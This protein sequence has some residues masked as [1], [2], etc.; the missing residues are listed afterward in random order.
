MVIKGL[1]YLLV[2]SMLLSVFTMGISVAAQEG[3]VLELSVSVRD[4]NGNPI[5]SA[6]IYFDEI[7]QGNTDSD[8]LLT[9]SN[10]RPGSHMIEINL[11]ELHRGYALASVTDVSIT[12]GVLLESSTID[13]GEV[14]IIIDMSASGTIACRINMWEE[15]EADM[16]LL[17]SVVPTAIP[18]PGT[19]QSTADKI[20]W[21]GYWW[22]MSKGET[23][24]GYYPHNA[25]GPLEKYD[26]YIEAKYGG[27]SQAKEWELVNHYIPGCPSWFGHCHAWA[28]AAILEGEPRSSITKEGII[29]YV[30]DLKALLTECH[31][32]DPADFFLGTRFNPTNNPSHAYEDVYAN[33]FT[34][35]IRQWI[36]DR[37][38]PLVMD[39]D[40]GSEV[41]NHPFYKYE[42]TFTPADGN[43]VD[44]ACTV[45]H[46]TD[47]VHA[48]HLSDVSSASVFTYTYRYWITID[49]SGEIVTMPGTSGWTSSR[50]PDFL[51]HPAVSNHP[52]PYLKCDKV[53][54]IV[55]KKVSV[56]GI[57]RSN[58]Y[59][60][61]H[62]LKIQVPVQRIDPNQQSFQLQQQVR[63][64]A[65]QVIDLPQQDYT[66]TQAQQDYYPTYTIPSAW[67]QGSYDL[68]VKLM[69]GAQQ[70]YSSSWITDAFMVQQGTPTQIEDVQNIPSITYT[71]QG[72]VDLTIIDQETGQQVGKLKGQS[73]EGTDVEEPTQ[74]VVQI[75]QAT[76]QQ[77]EIGDSVT[78]NVQVSPNPTQ[79][80]AS[81]TL[82]ATITDQDGEA[83]LQQ[84]QQQQQ[85]QTITITC[86]KETGY[87]TQVTGQQSGQYTQT[88]TS[89]V[90]QQTISQQT[91]QQQIEQGQKH[92]SATQVSTQSGEFT[93][94]QSPIN[95]A[96]VADAGPYQMINVGQQVQFDG[97]G[98]FDTDGSIVSYYWDFG[99]GTMGSG[100][101]PFHT[102][103]SEGTYTVFLT[104][105]DDKGAKDIDF[106]NI[107][108]VQP[109]KNVIE[110]IGA[111]PDP[112]CPQPP[113]NQNTQITAIGVQGL[114]PLEVMI[115]REGWPEPVQIIELTEFPV[116]VTPPEYSFS[117]YVAT[118]D[119]MHMTWGEVVPDGEYILTIYTQGDDQELA[120]GTVT[121]NCG[122]WQLERLWADPDPF[123]P[124]VET[125][126]ITA[127]GDSG[128]GPLD[129][130]IMREGWPEPD[131]ILPLTEGPAGT[132]TTTWDGMHMHG[133][134]VPDDEYILSV[135]DETGHELIS[136]T[137]TV[138]TEMPLT[139]IDADPDPFNPV[140]GQTTLITATGDSGL[141]PLELWILKEE[142]W[143]PVQILPMMETDGIY[144][145]RWDGRHMHGYIVPDG[146]YILSI[147]DEVGE[148]ISGTVTVDTG[149]AEAA[150]MRIKLT[151][152]MDGTDVDLHLI[153]PGGS[154]GTLGDCYWNNMYPDWDG[155]G[156]YYD[157]TD[158]SN[159]DT[160]D[161]YLD[162]DNMDGY[163]PEHITIYSPPAGTYSVVVHYWNDSGHGP[164]D[165]TVTVTL[166][167]G[168]TNEIVETF[169]PHT[170]SQS[171]GWE[172]GETWEAT[173][174]T[175]PQGT[176]SSVAQ[177]TFRSTEAMPEK[178]PPTSKGMIM[179]APLATATATVTAAEY[180]IDAVGADGTGQAMS[181]VD[182]AFDSNA[183]EVT[184]NVD[185][186]ELSP[187]DHTLFVHGRDTDGWG[188]TES[189]VLSVTPPGEQTI[190]NVA[191]PVQVVPQGSSFI[192]DV[193]VDPAE[194]ITGAQFDLRFNASLVS[195]DSVTEGDLLKQGG[196]NT[197]FNPG[198]I[199]N[200]AGMITGVAG[201][202]TTPGATVSSSGV[203]ATI[204]MTAKS[205]GGT[206]P[207]NLS[208]VIVGDINGNPVSIIV[209]DGS[210][211]IGALCGDL[212]RDGEIT[213]TD[214]V[215]A[216]EIA[217]GSRPFDGAAD[218][219]NDG[220]VTS[221][222][223]LMI[224]QAAVGRIEIG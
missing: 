112:F 5:G 26:Q 210:A 140:I 6:P 169:G 199:D 74:V 119:G 54:E 183:E 145:A 129:L 143:E 219:D 32:S 55:G 142:W 139:S 167:E 103:A 51:W 101:S 45:W 104:V 70:L 83:L 152:N 9:L 203:L 38:E 180:F 52:N 42:M 170:L 69:D 81:V 181:A 150:D 116:F 200:T 179:T 98:S 10:L 7:F 196:A 1:T 62:Q 58:N 186:S 194:S 96:P 3:D 133:Y 207:L 118:W 209:D 117:E 44:V 43:K 168:T 122:E 161:P 106:T 177:S 201:A 17:S 20:P 113:F 37:G 15:A 135:G 30:G 141:G 108:V 105:T 212:N 195:A 176:F 92:T 128:L 121:V 47:G 110:G 132:Y 35:A 61:D 223:A 156:E 115:T 28:A 158:P 13:H 59:Y 154:F 138:R 204:R 175:M 182:G 72:Q 217:T 107:F 77:T 29:F 85:Q 56:G 188:A 78:S 187:G 95:I 68:K 162:I 184:A 160:N 53:G 197:Y 21:A 151:W 46:V 11:F 206:S 24:L 79:G 126:L 164:S 208:N 100:V 130:W 131:Q 31:Y 165:A 173:T 63:N 137:V 75:P 211:I 91:T 27:D 166:H 157:P 71:T 153:K 18:V 64:P 216:L 163:G 80:A 90:G 25:P 134:I 73:V 36:K 185:V 111:Y 97:S 218:V 190:V 147:G 189:V 57:T 125:T 16:E 192:V 84:Q 8:G 213:T 89:K 40:P 191:P 14:A 221:I 174:V 222:D 86:P 215:I 12:D 48:D 136:G 19:E 66:I 65:G 88:I 82:T 87:T 220:A 155:D 22:P 193:T 124:N 120:T 144:T 171:G 93:T 109:G 33:D 50:H 76:Y 198:T 148:L 39:Y 123:N 60:N 172:T 159:N 127:T 23:A 67:Q 214:A 4:A 34:I 99:D 178:E 41:W 224:L 94:Q 205:V 114:S 102:Y 146:E 149:E 2:A 202:I 49:Q